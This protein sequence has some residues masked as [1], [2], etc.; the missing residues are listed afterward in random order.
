MRKLLVCFAALLVLAGCGPGD[1][2]TSFVQKQAQ[3]NQ[4]FSYSHS[5]TLS[6]PRAAVSARFAAARDAC[7]N[8]A[9]LDCT[10]V[11]ASFDAGGEDGRITASL[12]VALP[13]D[14][15][16]AFEKKLT[17]ALPEDGSGKVKVTSRSTTAENVTGEATDLDRKIAQL[18]AYRDR[19][20]ALAE[21]QN[22]GVDDLIKIEK[23]LSNT[24]SELDE[25]TAQ[26]KGVGARAAKE[27]V[28]VAM[29]AE[30]AIARPILRVWHHA[31]EDL[32]GSA[33]IVLQVLIVFA[34]WA[35]VIGAIVLI[36]F[37]LRRLF[38]RGKES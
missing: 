28:H 37:L 6:M 30:V 19:L 23:E 5:I 15:V 4:L 21:R 26:R 10:L 7:L 12:D 1:N 31:G 2:S 14:K 8:E 24:Q 18:T 38:R 9:A 13:H 11:N 27:S 22:A 20:S 25:A 17:Q 3:G 36:V 35:L 16:E 33:A 34:P 29:N 32:A